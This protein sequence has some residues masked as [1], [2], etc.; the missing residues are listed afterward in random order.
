MPPRPDWDVYFLG[1]A[2]AV[3]YRGDCT[4]SRVGAVLVQENRVVSTGYNGAPAGDPGCLTDGACPRGK[5]YLTYRYAD[6]P[7]EVAPRSYFGPV[8]AGCGCGHPDYPCPEAS[9]PGSPYDNC[10]AIH[11]EANALLYAN[12]SDCI[13]AAMYLT[14]EPCRDCTKLIRGARIKTV[15]W[16]EGRIDD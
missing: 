2:E 7:H 10:I 15:V 6:Y 4:R 12:R 8:M 13:G 14:R 1:L 11:A 9:E 16:P 5:H 3:S